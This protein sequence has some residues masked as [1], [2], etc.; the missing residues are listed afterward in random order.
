MFV[1]CNIKIPNAL[2]YINYIEKSKFILL[3]EGNGLHGKIV[4]VYE[5]LY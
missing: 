2:T 5:S 4:I 3:Y 1:H